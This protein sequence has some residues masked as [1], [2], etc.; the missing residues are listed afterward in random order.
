MEVITVAAQL[1]ALPV[2]EIATQYM[3]KLCVISLVMLTM[4]L[5]VVIFGFL[6]RSYHIPSMTNEL[7]E[8]V[9][10]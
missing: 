5:D 9:Q 4:K 7:M 6:E 10:R 2:N 8:P 3:R 1:T